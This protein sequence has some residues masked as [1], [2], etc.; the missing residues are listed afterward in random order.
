MVRGD[1]MRWGEVSQAALREIIRDC[2]MRLAAGCRSTTLRG[3]MQPEEKRKHAIAWERS[4][5]AF[6]AIARDAL[7]QLE[8]R[9]GVK[10]AHWDA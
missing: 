1:G 8:E 6:L 7:R 9:E 4:L 2:E 10:L 3:S 5:Q